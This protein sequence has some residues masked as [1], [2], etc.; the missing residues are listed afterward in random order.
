MNNFKDLIESFEEFNYPRVTR[1]PRS[2]ELSEEFIFAEIERLLS[3]YKELTTVDQ[4]ARLIRDGIDM[5]L[6]RYHGYAV[7][8]SIGS[9]YRE[10]GVSSSLC[11]F[12]HVIPQAKIRD[13]LIKEKLTIRQAMNPPTCLIHKQNHIALKQAGWAS[14]TPS[15]W[16]FFDRYTGVFTAQFET[17]NGQLITNPHDWT[18]ETH[19]NYFGI[20]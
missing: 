19:Y 9:H 11:D 4:R 6:R 5:Y 13:L 7:E 3:M 10:V 2:Y 8:G 14:K 12:E 16:H 1:G 15:I 17:H 18:L 20:V